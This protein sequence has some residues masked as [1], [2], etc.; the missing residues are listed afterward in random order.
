[1]MNNTIPKIIHQIWIGPKKPPLWCIESWKINFCN[2]YTDWEYI[3]WSE[4][5]INNLN[6]INNDIYNT[7]TTLRGKSDI[8]RYEI[9]YQYG[10]VF[11][12]ADSFWI[13]NNKN[14]DY[15]INNELN[16]K[17]LFC[18]NEP[19]NTHLFANGVIG[20]IKNSNIILE[21]INYLNKNYTETKLKNNHKYSIWK[22]TGP[23]PFTNVIKLNIKNVK[24]LP[25]VYFYP[26][27][28]HSNNQKIKVSNM[29]KLFPNSY[30]YQYWLSH[31]D[32]YKE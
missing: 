17:E 15:I 22:V 5:E 7:E 2:K 3:L 1:M 10:G 6:M 4:K 21:I 28:Y 31:T 8:A 11:L 23:I 18:A 25:S 29:K 13:D 27:S 9:L 14:L 12:D 16:N 19:K 30:M 20:C 26:E 32:Y 24:V